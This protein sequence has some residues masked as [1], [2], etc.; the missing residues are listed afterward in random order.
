M[1]NEK[2]STS[3]WISAA[4]IAVVVVIFAIC[5]AL[6][7]KEGA[8]EGEAFGGTDSAVTEIIEEEGYEPW[9]NPLLD[10]G[11]GEIE[12]GLFALQAAIGSGI[13]FFVLGNLRGRRKSAEEIAA[14]TFDASS[15]TGT[16]SPSRE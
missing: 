5:F 3:A 13:L 8:D 2:K 7:P 11:S 10:L 1:P 4:L 15:F 9:M 14:G 6:A 16:S 12:S